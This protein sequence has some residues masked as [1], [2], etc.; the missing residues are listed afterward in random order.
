MSA[1]IYCMYELKEII[2]ITT[3][4]LSSMTRSYDFLMFKGLSFSNSD[5][6]I[7]WGMNVFNLKE[8]L[9]NG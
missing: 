6:L 1:A 4:G 8:K 2:G 7:K 3:Q 9:P 5:E